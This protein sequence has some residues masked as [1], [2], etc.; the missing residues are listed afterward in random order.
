MKLTVSRD[1]TANLTATQVINY[2]VK[3]SVTSL[4]ITL[5]AALPR[6]VMGTTL[7]ACRSSIARAMYREGGHQTI[8]P[9]GY[10][11]PDY[12]GKGLHSL[13][14]ILKP[15]SP[16]NLRPFLTVPHL[17]CTAIR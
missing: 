16:Q 2:R 5:G 7:T 3:G 14:P 15:V 11:F 6:A 8:D 17:K 13:T 4:E 12:D 1:A 10:F 9:E